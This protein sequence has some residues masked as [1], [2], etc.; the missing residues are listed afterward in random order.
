MA[1]PEEEGV[2]DAHSTSREPRQRPEPS[3]SV[4]MPPEMEML[5]KF[6]DFLGDGS[7]PE[8]AFD[9]FVEWYMSTNNPFD[10]KD[11]IVDDDC[12]SIVGIAFH[13]TCQIDEMPHSMSDVK[14]TKTDHDQTYS[15]NDSYQREHPVTHS[16][17][18]IQIDI[19]TVWYWDCTPRLTVVADTVE[20]KVGESTSIEAHMW[21]GQ[22]P[23]QGREIVFLV[24]GSGQVSPSVAQTTSFGEAKTTLLALDEGSIT[25]EAAHVGCADMP[26]EKR[27]RD[28]VT[29]T[30]GEGVQLWRGILEIDYHGVGGADVTFT[31]SQRAE[32]L[33][34]FLPIS[35]D[36]SYTKEELHLLEDGYGPEELEIFQG[37]NIRNTPVD[38]E[39]TTSI[40]VQATSPGYAVRDVSE[41]N[42][43]GWWVGGIVEPPKT[44][45]TAHFR[46]PAGY[47]RELK[48]P[49]LPEGSSGGLILLEYEFWGPGDSEWN[50]ERRKYLFYV[51]GFHSRGRGLQLPF[52]D[53]A[54]DEGSVSG[55]LL[56][57]PSLKW[58]GT[59]RFEISHVSNTRRSENR[60]YTKLQ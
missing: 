51:R 42:I 17:T 55:E 35:M 14:G 46:I 34:E 49:E 2:I 16:Q 31:G 60:K 56:G 12:Y 54:R 9:S 23:M 45:S 25:V 22:Q 6:R 1:R 15:Y 44:G 29:I 26:V 24:T 28:S 5:D 52:V 58:E 57:N 47:P 11:V 10:L 40:S 18:Q 39:I 30:V 3:F 20:L 7:N 8:E 38:F 21:C 53:G 13:V 37:T 50:Y 36:G 43:Q 48:Y 33:F 27:F 4:P 41:T 32:F 19:V 59:F